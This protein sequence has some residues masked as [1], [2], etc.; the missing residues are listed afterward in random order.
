MSPSHSRRRR[1]GFTLMEVL[2]V[3]AILVI[4]G[5]L[6]AMNFGNVLGD[7]DRKAARSQIGL[8]EP[9]LKMYFLHLKDYPPTD[10][11]LEALRTPPTDLPNPAKWQGPYLEKPVPLDPW[12]RPYQYAYPGR[13][14]DPGS[15]D[16]WSLGKDGA[17]GTDD[18]IG[19]WMQE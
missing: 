11:G 18:D 8:F 5:A 13:Y 9:A 3:L 4:L 10:M 7:A 6:V 12:G 15:Y 14:S 17:D 1:G 2:L 16:L 19:N